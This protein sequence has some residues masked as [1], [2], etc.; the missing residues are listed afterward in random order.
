MRTQ[1][2]EMF[3]TC[4]SALP[5]TGGTL[6]PERGRE[7]LQE[8]PTCGSRIGIVIGIPITL[9]EWGRGGRRRRAWVR[10]EPRRHG[11]AGQ[12]RR[13]RAAAVRVARRPDGAVGVEQV[14]VPA[15]R[16]VGRG[17]V[18]GRGRLRRVAAARGAQRGPGAIG[19]ELGAP[20]RDELQQAVQRGRACRG[21]RRGARRARSAVFRYF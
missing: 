9:G 8:Q 1:K 6:E 7:P 10:R 13:A 4:V 11:G 16:A 15:T 20:P 3:N 17:V 21:A 12:R 2:S 14:H 5:A 19:G 18:R